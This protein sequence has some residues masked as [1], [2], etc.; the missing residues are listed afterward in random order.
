MASISAAWTSG[1]RASSRETRVR[2]LVEDL[3]GREALPLRLVG[4]GLLEG[5]HQ[6]GQ[7]I[8]GLVPLPGEPPALDDQARR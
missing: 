3:A 4:I 5:V 6:E 7:G 8:A 1:C 2:A